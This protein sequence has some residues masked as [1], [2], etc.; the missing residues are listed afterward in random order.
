MVND[1]DLA[2][3]QGD[4]DNDADDIDNDNALMVMLIAVMK[5]VMMTTTRMPMLITT[6]ECILKMEY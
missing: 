1:E 5:I 6:V 4:A 3:C 2:E